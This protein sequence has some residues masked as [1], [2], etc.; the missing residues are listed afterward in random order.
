MNLIS[1]PINNRSGE[2]RT[3]IIT[4]VDVVYNAV[5]VMIPIV[6]TMITVIITIIVVAILVILVFI[7][8]VISLRTIN[9]IKSYF[10]INNIICFTFFP[11]QVWTK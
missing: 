2:F 5:F 4:M 8:V 11:Y 6:I 10:S 3:F 9:F 7:I 1:R